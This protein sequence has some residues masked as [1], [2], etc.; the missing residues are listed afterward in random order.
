MRVLSVVSAGAAALALTIAAVAIAG[1]REQVFIFQ[2]ENVLGTSL[3]LKVGA[4]SRAQAER[5]ETALVHEID[6]ESSILSSWSPDSEFSRWA[7]THDQAVPVS[8]ELFEVLGLYDQWRERTKGALNPSAGEVIA[9]WK[10]AERAGHLPSN[11]ALDRAVAAASEQQWTLDPVRHTATHTGHAQLVLATFTKSYIMDRAADAA[12]RLGVRSIVLNV[13]GDIV[14]RG[15]VTEPVDVAD[16]RD[17]AE[18]AEPLAQLLIRD[19][20]IATS[21][22]YRR[23]FEIDGRRYSHIVDPRTGMPAARIISST[24]IAPR[25]SDAGA[26]AT[27]FCILTPEESA[28]LAASVP[29]AAYMLVRADGERIA[30]PGWAALEAPKVIA[31]PRPQTTAALAPAD[32]RNALRPM[33]SR[34]PLASRLAVAPDVAVGKPWDPSMELTVNFELAPI[35]G[36]T[37]RPFVAAWIEDA[38]HFQVRTLA[39][40]YHEDRWV[41]EMKAWFRSDRLRAMADGKEIFRSISSATRAPGKY[42]FKWDGK[43]NEGKLVK[44]GKYTVFLEVVREHGTYQLMKQEMDMTGTPKAVTFPANTEVVASSFDYHK[45]GK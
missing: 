12:M 38:D 24:V 10:E 9:V 4:S 17:D 32:N 21:G 44:N 20:E 19:R 35:G 25:A 27:A 7:R 18:N 6:R 22:D 45:L 8:P 36:A 23:G 26:L 42:T 41:T 16:P 11:D 40:W 37:K 33:P 28:A 30:S 31:A 39:V 2:R 1:V 29:A 43:D 5:A 15:A 14:V 13:G 34:H 3:D